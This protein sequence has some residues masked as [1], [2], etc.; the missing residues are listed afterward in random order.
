[1]HY[2]G[3]VHIGLYGRSQ[4]VEEI[5]NFIGGYSRLSSEEWENSSELS[6]LSSEVSFHSS[7][8]LFRP[9]VGD[10]CLLAGDLRFP[11]EGSARETTAPSGAGGANL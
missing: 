5:G 10:F 1:M 8:L 11:R 9:S 4:E 7:E 6:F 2:Y 3:R